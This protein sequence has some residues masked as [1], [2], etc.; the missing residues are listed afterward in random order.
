MM[1]AHPILSPVGDQLCGQLWRCAKL[2]AQIV[3]E[4]GENRGNIWLME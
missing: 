4:Y 2:G 3:N 1:R